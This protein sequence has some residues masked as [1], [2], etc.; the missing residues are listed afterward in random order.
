MVRFNDKG[1]WVMS[2]HVAMSMMMALFPFVLFVVALAATLSQD[3][4]VNNLIELVF[5]SWPDEIAQPITNEVRKVLSS[6]HSSLL[7][8]GG[9][10]AIY[11]ASNGVD[12]VRQAMTRAY[13]DNDPR[14]Y[15]RKRLLCLGF[16]IVGGALILIAAAIGVAVPLYMRFVA[17]AV[18]VQIPGWLGSETINGVGALAM[19]SA[20]VAA[21]HI[22]LPGHRHSLGQILPGVVLTVLLW[23]LA[24]T[25]FSFYLVRFASYS[26]TYAGLAGVMVALIFLYLMAAILILGAEFNGALIKRRAAQA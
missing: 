20:G 8:V 6:D 2:S 1:G 5:G 9:V 7:T 4:D 15:W 21:C 19:L 3:I 17:D 24:G 16:V 13:R 12:A 18:P 14:P 11:F 26:A 23:G 10:L 25:G 22:W